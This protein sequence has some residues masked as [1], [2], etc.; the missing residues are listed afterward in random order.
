[1]STSSTAEAPCFMRLR[2][3]G[4]RYGSTVVLRDVALDLAPGRCTALVGENGAGKS[5]LVGV[6]SGGITPSTGTISVDGHDVALRTP[7]DGRER[8]IVV[9]PQELS[10]VPHLSVAENVM[11]ANWPRHRTFASQ[12]WMRRRCREIFDDLVID[13]DVRRTMV[14]LPLAARQLVEIAKALA[15]D[16]RLLI[17]DEPTAAL[18]AGERD[19]LLERLATLKTRGVGL[20]YVSHHLDECF[21]VADDILVLRNGDVVDHTPTSETTPSRTTSAMLGR[22]YHE[23]APREALGDESTPALEVSG[24]SRARPPALHDLSFAVHEGEVLGMFGLIGSGAESVARGLGG[25]DPGIT[26]SIV[27]GSQRVP[28]PVTPRHARRLSIAYVPAERKT[29]G[30][31]LSQSVGEHLTMMIVGRFARLGWVRKRMQRRAARGL[32]ERFD[33]RCRGVQ[34]E[35]EQLSGGN[36]QKLLL[37]SRIAAEPRILVLHEPTR[38]VDIGSRAQIHETLAAYARKGA[39]VVVVTSDLQEATAATDRLL[40]LRDGRL[41]AELVGENKTDATALSLATGGTARG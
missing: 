32:V 8:G 1:M 13:V 38:G 41:V 2:G 7:R 3:V 25:H 12:R 36:Q 20:V 30:L 33:V 35:A 19:A 17:F 40:I 37:A 6:M 11:L 18:H 5:T 16:A 24:W 27:T 34:Q 10:Y 29:D 21:A 9:V 14:E 15:S 4:K 28:V 22:E 39:A 23:P 26:G 31:A